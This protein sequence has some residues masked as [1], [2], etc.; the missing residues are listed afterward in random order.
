ME[1]WGALSV[2]VRAHPRT[3][4]T[5]E[6]RDPG[7]PA[8]GGPSGGRRASVC[9]DNAKVSSQHVAIKAPGT[10]GGGLFSPSSPSSPPC[11]PPARAKQTRV[12]PA[13]VSAPLRR[14]AARS[15]E[16]VAVQGGAD[17][18]GRGR[19]IYL[20]Y[21]SDH[22]CC[23]RWATSQPN[24]KTNENRRSNVA[25]FQV[26]LDEAKVHQYARASRPLVEPHSS[27]AFGE[28]DA[29]VMSLANEMKPLENF[30]SALHQVYGG[31]SAGATNFEPVVPSPSPAT[32]I[33]TGT[34]SGSWPSA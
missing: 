21:S 14:P 33:P 24:K 20:C 28:D 27:T 32:P 19:E 31:K 13:A 6:T 34:P 8:A 4:R 15:G 9:R 10:G 18:G 5:V 29:A 12:P 3:H 25:K 17:R 22:H 1:P 23:P 16:N 26:G 30:T 2:S 11:L 7:V